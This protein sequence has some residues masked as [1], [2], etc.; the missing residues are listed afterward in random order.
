VAVR[1]GRRIYDNV[2]KSV[3]FLVSTNLS[4]IL[5]M[6]TATSAGLGQPLNAM[7]LLWINLMTDVAPALALAFEPPEPDLLRR[8][9]RRP[10]ESIIEYSTLWRMGFESAVLSAGALGAYGYGLLRHG[11]GPRAGTMAFLSLTNAQL[12]HTFSCRSESRSVFSP[13]P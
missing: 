9:P 8:P 13:D 5:V 3:H 10:D 1:E 6:L 12:L 2:R 11:P 4:E 7:Q